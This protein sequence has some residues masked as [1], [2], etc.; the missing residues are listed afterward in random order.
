MSTLLLFNTKDTPYGN[1]SPLADHIVSKSY[2]SLIKSK[3]LRDTVGKMRSDEARKESL[4]N[5]T[6]IQDENYKTFLKEAL[7]VKYKEGSPALDALLYI[8]EDRIVYASTNLFLG[9]NEG[10]G[11]NFVGN[12]LYDIRRK[13]R[14]RL[15]LQQKQDQQDFINKV[16]SVY[17]LFRYEIQSGRNNLK[18]YTGKGTIDEIIQQRLFEDMPVEFAKDIKHSAKDIPSFFFNFPESIPAV[19]QC[20]YHTHYNEKCHTIKKEELLAFY[21]HHLSVKCK[22]KTPEM[23][24]QLLAKLEANGQIDSLLARLEKY[25]ELGFFP[26]FAYSCSM[27]SEHE[28]DKK[29]FALFKKDVEQNKDDDQK[30]E[31]PQNKDVKVVKDMKDM[32]EIKMAEEMKLNADN[33]LRADILLRDYT[34]S[35]YDD[36]IH[37]FYYEENK[38]DAAEINLVYY[39][40]GEKKTQ[41]YR[42][43]Y[44]NG[45]NLLKQLLLGDNV[46][47]EQLGIRKNTEEQPEEQPEVDKRR[48]EP[49]VFYFNEPNIHSP[50]HYMPDSMYIIGTFRYPSLMHYVYS[51]M[52]EFFD[53]NQFEAYRKIQK[54]ISDTDFIFCDFQ[55]MDIIYQQLKD[56]YV[57]KN[58]Q[59]AFVELT[60]LKYAPTYTKEGVLA[61]PSKNV[62][63]LLSTLKDYKEISF[64]DKEEYILGQGYASTVL[65][66]IRKELYGIYGDID[67]KALEKEKAKKIK[68][69]K[70][71]LKDEDIR[72]FS[73]KKAKDLYEMMKQ[74]KDKFII[75]IHPDTKARIPYHDIEAFNFIFM[76]FLHCITRAKFVNFDKS[77]VPI[78]FK[79]EMEFNVS[80]DCME[81]LWKYTFFVYAST[82]QISNGLGKDRTFKLMD[83]RRQQSVMHAL[84]NASLID[85]DLFDTLKVSKVHRGREK[86]DEDEDED[87][88]GEDEKAERFHS[89]ILLYYV[90]GFDFSL[91]HTNSESQYSS[92]LPKHVKQVNDIM[93][94]WFT[95]PH[96]IIDATAHIG[97][98][99]VHFAKMFPTATIDSFE[100]NKQTFDLLVKNVDAF[101]LSSKVSIHHSSF[102]NAD[103]DQKSSFIYIDAPWGGKSYKNIEMGEFEL[104]LDAINIKEI[105]RRL[106]ASGKT[107]TVVL[108]VPRNYRFDD[109]KTKY[110][111]DVD[112]EDVKDE[113]RISYVLLK[114][115]LPE[116][117]IQKCF[118]RSLCVSSFLTIF[119]TLAKF[120]P[121]FKFDENALKF[122]MR[123]VYLSDDLVHTDKSIPSSVYYQNLLKPYFMKEE[124][125]ECPFSHLLVQKSLTLASDFQQCI[126]SIVNSVSE[127][128]VITVTSRI[129]LFAKSRKITVKDVQKQIKVQEEEDIKPLDEFI[130]EE[131]NEE[132]EDSKEEEDYGDEDED[133]DKDDEDDEDKDR[134]K[135]DRYEDSDDNWNS[136]ENWDD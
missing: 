132:N 90:E 129:L 70:D 114:L 108:K 124:E 34:Y 83:K 35:K 136:D 74:F 33:L 112:R 99:T 2:A 121:D 56:E 96:H 31:S 65:M 86:E 100:V 92:L 40:D 29:L 103:L 82:M 1:L 134:N 73:T 16:Y 117:E 105:A 84:K 9:M 49:T 54:Q 42:K 8:R 13:E 67:F 118:I 3:M 46:Y 113:G 62:I 36:G 93:K 66:E 116:Q 135:G 47:S 4:K 25:K 28:L 19:L 109:L 123:L 85:D 24:K 23:K 126:E 58:V 60:R 81:E 27:I 44:I 127:Y 131:E 75:G 115:T 21:I 26:E 18:S 15:V 89:S 48:R 53:F 30:H 95:N 77:L 94:G 133:D 7:D 41:L 120:I 87:E 11:A 97:V 32:K 6:Q 38:D 76:N 63:L 59:R 37:E 68:T 22:F 43:D 52:I 104:Y 107:D 12:Y 111:F 14:A 39:V 128:N 69:M 51:K 106:I 125:S 119:D 17:T 110:G 102:I 101:K 72:I 57:A 45:V 80:K 20:L 5:F 91:F 130:L 122:A 10:E 78:D 64:T 55:E 98:D 79:T 61:V 50:Y 88:K 71:I